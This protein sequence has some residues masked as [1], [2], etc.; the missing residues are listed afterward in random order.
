[1]TRTHKTMSAL[2]TGLLACTLV[3]SSATAQMSDSASGMTPGQPFV[4]AV[5]TSS[6]TPLIVVAAGRT[7]VDADRRVGIYLPDLGDA[8]GQGKDQ[9]LVYVV[10]TE[11]ASGL[12]AEILGKP[13]STVGRV[14]SQTETAAGAG[15]ILGG[16]S[17]QQKKAP[18]EGPGM[19]PDVVKKPQEK[20]GRVHASYEQAAGAGAT[21]GGSGAQQTGSMLTIGASGLQHTLGYDMSG[22]IVWMDD[23]VHGP[24]QPDGAGSLGSADDGLLQGNGSGADGFSASVGGSKAL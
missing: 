8:G 16:S 10:Y 14:H 24:Y 6:G 20:V 7:P 11:G 1:M 19:A 17:G 23:C 2:V 3:S 13:Q 9:K 4:V 12:S 18:I 5:A 15:A 21:L 22:D